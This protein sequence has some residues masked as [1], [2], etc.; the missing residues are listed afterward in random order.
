MKHLFYSWKPYVTAATTHERGYIIYYGLIFFIVIDI[1]IHFINMLFLK[2]NFFL[3]FLI[4]FLV[5]K[6]YNYLIYFN[7]YFDFN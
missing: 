1:F 4:Y 6:I 3:I 7:I 5:I 2:K